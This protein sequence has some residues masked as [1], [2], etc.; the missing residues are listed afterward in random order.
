MIGPIFIEEKF[1]GRFYLDSIFTK[2]EYIKMEKCCSKKKTYFINMKEH[3]HI[4]PCPYE[5]GLMKRFH[6]NESDEGAP[7]ASETTQP[8]VP[9]HLNNLMY[10]TQRCDI[11]ELGCRIMEECQRIL[12]ETFQNVRKLKLNNH[13]PI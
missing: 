9:W 8:N 12:P 5:I 3:L 6:I 10:E 13:N 2:T 7:M 1:T 11:P 4:M